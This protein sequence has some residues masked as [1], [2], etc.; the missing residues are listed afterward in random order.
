[1]ISAVCETY[2][3]RAVVD[4]INYRA[5][6]YLLFMLLFNAGMWTASTGM[7]Y[8]LCGIVLATKLPNQ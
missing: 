2:L 5:G 6:R 1:M 4:K 3:Y 7:G 8:A